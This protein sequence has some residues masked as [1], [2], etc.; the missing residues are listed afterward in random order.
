MKT[1]FENKIA[2]L[3]SQKARHVIVHFKQSCKSSY[4]IFKGPLDEK[5]GEHI[6]AKINASVS[7]TRFISR[8]KSSPNGGRSM[9][10]NGWR[11][12][13]ATM[14]LTNG[15]TWVVGANACTAQAYSPTWKSAH[16]Q[17]NRANGGGIGSNAT[18]KDLWEANT[19]T[20]IVCSSY[21]VS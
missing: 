15:A 10:T 16:A 12:W 7:K 6:K 4:T 8:W 20:L 19:C 2:P 5:H 18:S 17:R 3:D 9:S 11:W 13:N 21:N 14:V 1:T